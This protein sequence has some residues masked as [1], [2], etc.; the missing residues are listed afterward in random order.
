MLIKLDGIPEVSEAACIVE[1][2]EETGHKFYFASLVVQSCSIQDYELLTFSVS[3]I[4]M[5]LFQGNK[6]TIVLPW[7]H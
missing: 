3:I 4:P 7:Y 1:A 2:R 5:S 6:T